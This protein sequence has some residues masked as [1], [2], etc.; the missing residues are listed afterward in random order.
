MTDT[1]IAVPTVASIASPTDR[2]MT[3]IASA[4]ATSDEGESPSYCRFVVTQ[5]FA[6]RLRHLQRVLRDNHLSELRVFD[7][8]ERWGPGNVADELRFNLAELVLTD[9]AFWFADKPKHTDYNI[10]SDLIA[11]QSLLDAFDAG[12]QQHL[13][14]VSDGD[15]ELVAEDEAQDALE[16]EPF[17][18]NF[19]I[20]TADCLAD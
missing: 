9:G 4:H 17:D 15:L 19:T 14:G 20:A 6:N 16:A 11:I 10:N 18:P 1:S 8:P 7:G 13:I 2:Q 3:V 5:A 12:E